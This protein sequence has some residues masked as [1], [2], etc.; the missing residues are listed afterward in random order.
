LCR[1]EALEAPVPA[2][3]RL[4]RYPSGHAPSPRSSLDGTDDERV[5]G[6]RWLGREQPNE[7]VHEFGSN[8]VPEEIGRGRVVGLGQ[9]R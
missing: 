6:D 1:R 8:W 2:A 4:G 5:I 3:E 7:H 9:L